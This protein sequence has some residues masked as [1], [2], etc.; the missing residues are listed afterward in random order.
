MNE[1]ELVP[2]LRDEKYRVKETEHGNHG[3][4]VKRES[5]YGSYDILMEE[6][7]TYADKTGAYDKM[8][9]LRL[10]TKSLS[11]RMNDKLT[12]LFGL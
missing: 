9:E 7:G 10:N 2:N 12:K 5:E 8:K 1:K 3:I 4:F 6:H 11:E